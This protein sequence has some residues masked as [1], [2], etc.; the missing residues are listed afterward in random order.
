M[1]HF[2]CL[3][4]DGGLWNLLCGQRI[5]PPALQQLL[6]L[7][8]LSLI[9]PFVKTEKHS[10]LFLTGA[11]LHS[12]FCCLLPATSHLTSPETNSRRSQRNRKSLVSLYGRVFRQTK[13]KTCCP[14]LV[15]YD[16]K[17]WTNKVRLENIKVI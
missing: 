5:T 10:K 16:T 8:Y 9:H 6:H 1:K 3:L 12:L 14:K 15:I 13:F 7:L 11:L 2:L 17:T 4:T